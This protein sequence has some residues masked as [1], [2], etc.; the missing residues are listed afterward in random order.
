MCSPGCFSL[1]RGS[2][3][4]DDHVLR[5]YSIK[6]TEASHYVQYDQG[7][8]RWLST[9]LIQQGYTIQYC[10]AAVSF[11]Y[12]PESFHVILV[13]FCI[14]M[15]FDFLIKFLTKEYYT[16]RRRWIPS[17]IAN[18]VDFLSD[19]K[20][21]LRTN[22]KISFVYMIYEFFMLAGSIIGPATVLLL[23]IDTYQFSFGADLLT[24]YF[25]GIAPVVI[26][27]IFCI[28]AKNDTQILVAIILSSIFAIVMIAVVI[29]TSTRVISSSLI[30]P[31]AIVF[32]MLIV[33]YLTAALM[34][35]REFTCIIPGAI[36]FLLLPS[37]FVILQIY[38]L[39]NLNNISWGTR[40][41]KKNPIEKDK[42]IKIESND[43]LTKIDDECVDETKSQSKKWYDNSL[44][45]ESPLIKLEEKEIYFFDSLIK[46]YL[47][48]IVTDEAHKVKITSDLSD[49]KNN[50]SF[51]FCMVNVIWLALI[52][53][54]QLIQRRA[55]KALF[56]ELPVTNDGEYLRYE[57]MGFFFFAL[58]IIVTIF[59]YSAMLWHRF[60][61]LLHLVYNAA[62]PNEILKNTDENPKYFEPTVGAILNGFE[63]ATSNN[64][65]STN[66]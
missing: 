33:V 23:L 14:F 28:F 37:T 65:I 38:A 55:Y 21:I 32:V 30:N 58:F 45:I 8:D 56:I 61:T 64:T 41:I 59:Q 15:Y 40:E 29:T 46:E 27:I 1:L 35:P 63:V 2:S 44:L 60:K 66:I 9:L 26:F 17:T 47:T 54:L 10:S 57:P 62:I 22:H 16:Q 36:Y 39:F 19:F 48:P 31:S 11:T 7:E 24:S 49:L 34:H 3:I 5:T 52:F 50:C 12:A 13:F 20:H 18:L 53:N 42:N 51:G 6:S 4:V 43:G 25:F